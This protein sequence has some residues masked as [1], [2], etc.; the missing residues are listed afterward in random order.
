MAFKWMDKD[1]TVGQCMGITQSQVNHCLLVIHI[2]KKP[3]TQ[4]GICHV[5]GGTSHQTKEKRFELTFQVSRLLERQLSRM[6]CPRSQ[7]TV[8]LRS[9][10]TFQTF[11][12]SKSKTINIWQ[13]MV[14]NGLLSTSVTRQ[15]KLDFQMTTISRLRTQ[16]TVLFYRWIISPGMPKN[17]CHG[18][19]QTLSNRTWL[20]VK[21][22]FMYLAMFTTQRLLRDSATMATII[23]SI[24]ALK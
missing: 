3:C 7:V 23:N 21:M 6:Q 13:M 22:W 5:Y 12:S 24:T 9:T 11:L 8:S 18:Y 4:Y 20:M 15:S 19:P 1:Q 16:G 10:L 14:K 2:Y 17:W